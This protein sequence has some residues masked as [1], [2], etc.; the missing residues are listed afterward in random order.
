MIKLGMYLLRDPAHSDEERLRMMRAAG[1]DFVCIG[2]KPY[3]DGDMR[4]TVAL[5]EKLGIPVEN[6]HLTGTKTTFIWDDTEEG[7]SIADRYCREIEYCSSLGV[8]TGIAH[9]TWG[10]RAVPPVNETALCRYER[11][12]DTAARCGFVL[13]LEN[14][15]YPEYL[16]A[17]ME[18]LHGHPGI[19]F[20]FDSGH[21]NAFAPGEDFLG[22]FGN[23]L[24]AIHLQDNNGA[25]D[26]HVMPFDGCAPWDEIARSL[27]NTSFARE[28]I[29]AE[30]GSDSF[31]AMKGMSAEEVAKSISPMAI[32]NDPSLVR[33]ADGGFYVYENLN[34]EQRLERLVTAMRKIAAM[35]EKYAAEDDKK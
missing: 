22:R 9:V 6:I 30:I 10:H 1:F 26:L 13:S 14:S 4:E 20:C 23:I 32:A 17:V 7:E 12:A 34:Y 33:V 31:K 2:T 21:R 24:S 28:K 5:C 18:R 35:I 11:I 16:Y 3:A 25:D 15:V 29:C 8:K 27:A 19:G